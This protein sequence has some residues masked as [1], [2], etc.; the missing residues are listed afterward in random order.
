MMPPGEL[1]LGSSC[2][3]SAAV[4]DKLAAALQLA[5]P[6]WILLPLA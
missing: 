4:P 6:A 2:L 1:I 3:R 5:V